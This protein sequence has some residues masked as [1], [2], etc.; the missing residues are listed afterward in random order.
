MSQPS[1]KSDDV[2][3]LEEYAKKYEAIQRQSSRR[4]SASTT[5]IIDQ[6]R[7]ESQ[8]SS[9]WSQALPGLEADSNGRES[10]VTT[11]SSVPPNIS[12]NGRDSVTS[13]K[14][15]SSNETLRVDATQLSQSSENA[16]KSSSPCQRSQHHEHSNHENFRPEV[17]RKM[18][19][20]QKLSL[21]Q[22]SSTSLKPLPNELKESSVSLRTK[23]AGYGP[24]DNRRKSDFYSLCDYRGIYK[25]QDL[26]GEEK[27]GHQPPAVRARENN[28]QSNSSMAD[29]SETS[30]V[31]N[32]S[33][34]PSVN[35]R[36]NQ[37][38]QFAR[39]SKQRS[40][41]DYHLSKSVPNL[42]SENAI[43]SQDE[44]AEKKKRLLVSAFQTVFYLDNN[45]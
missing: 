31:A 9:F 10:V 24:S 22:F 5:P 3:E 44:S 36:I 17:G 33:Q 27:A 23:S 19:S 43:S 29:E 35:D 8:Y 38:E 41:D 25:Q 26:H 42:V 34:P 20:S 39:T 11:M 21:L 7:R 4:T 14:S 2:N 1:G 6:L 45:H 30:P 16:S 12:P 13:G 32:S 40:E 28:L 37:I 18:R 15:D